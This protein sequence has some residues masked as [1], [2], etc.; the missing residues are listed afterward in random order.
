MR[1]S[2]MIEAIQGSAL[3]LLWYLSEELVIFVLFDVGL[4]SDERHAVAA[5]LSQLPNTGNIQPEK[6]V[7][8][9]DLKVNNHTIPHLDLF[10]GPRGYL[11]FNKLN[12]GGHGCSWNSDVE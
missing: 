3:K 5:R 12:A 4:N 9:V 11:L 2:T 6:P 7:F 8:P 10:V 1:Q